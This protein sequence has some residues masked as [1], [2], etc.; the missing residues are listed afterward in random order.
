WRNLARFD[1]ERG[2]GRGWLWQIARSCAIDRHRRRRRR[3]ALS[4]SAVGP[5][6]RM[7]DVPSRGPGPEELLA[8]KELADC[9]PRAVAAGRPAPEEWRGG[10][11]RADGARGGGAAASRTVRQIWER[12]PT[13]TYQEIADE[14]GLTR[15]SVIALFHRWKQRL[16]AGLARQGYVR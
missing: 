15:A 13:R 7:L 16:E 4:L 2:T 3:F 5:D 8:E 10:R 1:P 14:L 9:V 11:G 12:R 6:D